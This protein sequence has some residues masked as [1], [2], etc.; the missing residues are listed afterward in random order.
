MASAAGVKVAVPVED[1]IDAKEAQLLGFNLSDWTL[2]VCRWSSWTI[3][4]WE[5]V[6]ES[7]IG[8]RLQSFVNSFTRFLDY[9]DLVVPVGVLRSHLRHGGSGERVEFGVHMP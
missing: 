6:G 3:L 8:V 2:S 4:I 1:M 9:W 7:S 5:V